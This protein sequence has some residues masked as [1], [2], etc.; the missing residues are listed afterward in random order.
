MENN[1]K[2]FELIF[3]E[4]VVANL[5]LL[6]DFN[7]MSSTFLHQ[8]GH[9]EISRDLFVKTL[10]I[11]QERHPFFRASLVKDHDQAAAGKMYFILEETSEAV[12]KIQAEWL[13]LTGEQPPPSRSRLLQECAKF[14]AKRFDSNAGNLLWRGQLI[15][16]GETGEYIVNIVLFIAITDG[17]NSIQL[18]IEIVNILN[19]LATGQVCAEMR[20][21]LDAC[22]SLYYYC[23]KS[24]LIDEKKEKLIAALDKPMRRQTF[25]AEFRCAHETGF[26]LDFFKLSK[27]V[28]RRVI[29]RA[30]ENNTR[31]T[32]YFYTALFYALKK[33][34]AENELDFPTQLIF[35]FPASLRIRYKP[36]LD[37]A[38]CR[39]HISGNWFLMEAAMFEADYENF[40]Q[41]C[42]LVDEE[43]REATSVDKGALFA[44]THSFEALNEFNA[45][46][47][48]RSDDENIP[49]AFTSDL[50]LS[51]LGAFVDAKASLFPGPFEI[52]ELYCSDSLASDMSPAI[53]AHILYWRGEMMM[54]FGANKSLFASRYLDRLIEL[55]KVTIED[56][57]K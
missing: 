16:Y 7:V 34:Y 47:E 41:N 42:Q 9:A 44:S 57:L 49:Q 40:W 4:K 43:V 21:K 6:G 19:A 53:V 5:G 11:M 28:T 14:N 15:K 56:T 38:H 55:Y 33:V 23:K 27:D 35:Q 25:A 36:N 24:Q 30:K 39:M 26:K 17:F 2:K 54:Q 45:A 18:A 29:A 12:R 13:D 22:E 37:F 52:N 3:F 10:Q 32:A 50:S 20:V 8:T 1:E 51:N 46:F 48:N 31:L